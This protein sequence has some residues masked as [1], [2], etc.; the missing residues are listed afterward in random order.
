MLL[1]H[2]KGAGLMVCLFLGLAK[3]CPPQEV[4]VRDFE[5]EE[6]LKRASS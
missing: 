4:V 1:A 6:I 5:D 2:I 3:N